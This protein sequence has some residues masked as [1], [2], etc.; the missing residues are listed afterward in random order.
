MYQTFYMSTLSPYSSPPEQGTGVFNTRVESG[1]ATFIS[2]ACLPFPPQTHSSVFH[3]AL[4]T[5]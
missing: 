3:T 5:N 2:I 1:T 4:W